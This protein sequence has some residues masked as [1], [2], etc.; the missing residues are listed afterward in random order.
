MSYQRASKEQLSDV[1]MHIK[2]AQH[3]LD[4]LYSGDVHGH[5]GALLKKIEEHAH[6]LLS[7]TQR[8]K[9]MHWVE[10]LEQLSKEYKKHVS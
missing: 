6:Q 5:V 2:Q 7:Q 10:R 1:L 3:G 8:L 4:A 9:S